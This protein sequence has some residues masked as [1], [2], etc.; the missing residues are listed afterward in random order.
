MHNTSIA[1]PM[2]V[3]EL[4]RAHVCAALVRAADGGLPQAALV[5]EA[6]RGV[7]YQPP[8]RLRGAGRLEEEDEAAVEDC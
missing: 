2:T 6:R 4:A 7:E 1:H 3:H 8:L 5:V